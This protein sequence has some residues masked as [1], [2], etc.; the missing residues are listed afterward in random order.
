[1]AVEG[2]AGPPF[3]ERGL[4]DRSDEVELVGEPQ[5]L[6]VG[7][8]DMTDDH[9]L[10]LRLGRGGV[11]GKDVG[12]AT[13]IA[14]PWLRATE[15]RERGARKSPGLRRSRSRSETAGELRRGPLRARPVGS[16][17][18]CPAPLEL[19]PGRGRARLRTPTRARRAG[20]GCLS[21]AF[22]VPELLHHPLMVGLEL[23]DQLCRKTCAPASRSALP[24]EQAVG[25]G[26]LVETFSFFLVLKTGE[27]GSGH[28]SRHPVRLDAR[29]CEVQHGRPGGYRISPTRLS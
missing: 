19:S 8:P 23:G 9:F 26:P 14:K 16:P 17:P 10:P 28:G 22:Q 29:T 27:G 24:Q 15:R 2:E 13:G 5:S 25:G 1:M 20:R 4:S 11:G 7:G 21:V 12:D 3:P 6:P 18:N